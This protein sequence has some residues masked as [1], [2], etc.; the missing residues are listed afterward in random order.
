MNRLH[1]VWG[2]AFALVIAFSVGA[3]PAADWGGSLTTS[4]S[5]QSVPDGSDDDAFVNSERL[6]LYLTAPLGSSWELVAQG[7]ARFDTSPLFAADVEK[8]YFQNTIDFADQTAERE[9][10]QPGG[11]LQFVSRTGR[12]SLSEPTGLV[13]RQ[14]VD[15]VDVTVSGQRSRIDLGAGYAGLVNKEFSALSMSLQDSADAED[16]DVY[17]GPPRLLGRGTLA[18][19][20]LVARQNL[21][22]AFAFQQ[23]LRDPDSV[24]QDGTDSADVTTPGG[25]IDTQYAIARVDGPVPGV[26]TLFY[27]LT[28]VFN[29]GRVMGLLDD[30]AANS[31]SSYQYSPIRAHLVRG[32]VQYFL[33][34]FFSA[35]ASAAVTY[36]SGDDDYQ[37][38]TEGNTDGNA[39]MFTAA[40][41]SSQGAVFGLQSGNSTVAE[42]SWSM[43][44]FSGSS[45]LTESLLA[46]AVLYSFFRSAGSGPVSVSDVDAAT[47]GAYLGSEVD[48]DFRWRPFSDLGVGL[49]SGFLFANSDVM[50]DSA[51]S[52]DYVLRLNA[53]L[54][55]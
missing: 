17:F 49:T 22:L 38:F 51:N 15:G 13:L 10:Q 29:S 2:L 6:V 44:P 45:G 52:V 19:P 39:T 8:F 3:E 33:P 20:G 23:D 46:R 31:G 14:A 47:S 37:A 32:D 21:T 25:L 48:L 53:S 35:A 9:V 43:K 36:S 27:S 1:A 55:F 7:A 54:S 30:P 41:P 18:L 4:S 5:V 34:E 42:V 12:F 11:L 28:Y 50:L 16:G 26:G 24:V 40:T